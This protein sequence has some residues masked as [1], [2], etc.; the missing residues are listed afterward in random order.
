MPKLIVDGATVEVAEGATLLQ[1]IHAAGK[2]V[3]TLC[4]DDRLKPIGACRMC[5]VEVKGAPVPVASCA[6]P[7]KEGAVVQTATPA[8]V[9]E[10]RA[11][12][13]MLAA[14]YPADAP[15]AQPDK[16]FHQM[17]AEYGVV[18]R[19]ERS[20]PVDDSHP[21][22]HVDMSQCVTCYRC[23]RICAEVQGQDVWTPVG[24]GADTLMETV[25]GTSMKD[26][27]CVSCGAC[28][29]TCPSGAIDDKTLLQ[30]G[31]PERTVR[32]TCPYCGVGCELDVGVKGSRIVQILPA[33]DSPVNKGHT[34]VKGRYAWGFLGAKDRLTRPLLR[35]GS[36]FREVSYDEA[37]AFIARRLQEI[38]AAA[39]PGAVGVLGSS[40]ST[41]EEN[42]VA[43]KFARVA[44]GTNNVDCC[45]RVC[46]APTATA[47]AS[48]F[49]T[50]AA[51]SSYDDIEHARTI[52]VAGANATE[53]HP[54]IGA[55]VRQAA[56]RGAAL[57]VV[58]PR[59]TELA[60]EADIH[61]MLKPGTNVP[62]FQ[63]LA[64]VIL[65]DGL[66]D[67]S[68][69]KER[70]VDV[71][72]FR[73]KVAWA[74]PERVAELCHVPAEL[75]VKAAHLFATRKPG[76]SMHGLG[77]TE[78]LQGSD[79]VAALS[80]LALLTG[81]LGEL[82]SGV[83]P[84]RGQNNVQGSAHMGCEPSRLT[85]YVPVA[86]GRS[87]H[88]LLWGVAVP[89]EAGLDLMQMMD[90]AGEGKLRALWCMGYDVAHT[91]PNRKATLAALKRLELLV[92]QDLFLNETAREAAHVVL[93]AAASFEKD[94]TFMNAERRVS[95][96]RAAVPPPSPDCKP[97]WVGLVDVA[98]ALGH[99]ERFA[100]RNIEEVWDE[101]RKAWPP[102]RGMS[103][104]RLEKHGLQ[105]P[106]PT[107]DHPGTT[108][109]HGESFT[110]G[111]TTRLAFA[112]FTETPERT[113]A[114]HPFLL[115]TGRTLAAFNANTMTGR[116]RNLE[117]RPTDVLEIHPDDA[118]RLGVTDGAR[119]RMSNARGSVELPVRVTDAVH[120]GE[121]YTTFHDA[122]V[123]VNDLIG[124]VR[125]TGA[126]TPEYKV[127][128]VA[129]AP[130]GG[131]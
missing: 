30:L 19:G 6:T 122:R 29:S 111:K 56:R 89:A 23:A 118:R 77:M 81:N 82:G 94:G 126:H 2:S 41:N 32:T 26:S 21:Y 47:M 95:R 68:F 112:P 66:A 84:L 71:D 60:R 12:L 1:A 103:Y 124:D 105:W 108:H 98:R 59:R 16:P 86:K 128:A 50:G 127:T 80:D 10:R 38:L 64:H 57:I 61:L 40:R 53:N 44:L 20:Q 119:V 96:V 91:N 106:C 99:G 25:T 76:M 62:V 101:V 70:L 121:L 93:P 43:Q 125:D 28:A 116:T 22:L 74:T 129:L 102:G 109:L 3:P 54:V 114:Q 42:Y 73:D 117:I 39:G 110:L 11:L 120:P 51:T 67:E 90:A 45:A 4:H 36:G 48:V 18:A 27:P 63:C 87:D 13:T 7:A 83:N 107:E 9:E 33:M 69:A 37:I 88:E 35:D 123:R 85:G 100:W 130:V 92:V 5:L 46:H 14:D 49:G 31:A 113:S 55:R 15:A 115:V 78:H 97:D 75:L 34:C 104:R 24:R 79:G 65:R 8:L 131:S 58:D 52:L 72:A 17:L